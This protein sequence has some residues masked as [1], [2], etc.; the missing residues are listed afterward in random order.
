MVLEVRK[1]SMI[2]GEILRPSVL[3]CSLKCSDAFLWVLSSSESVLN[4]LRHTRMLFDV[5]FRSLTF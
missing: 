5:L 4:V 2:L 1:Y 3:L